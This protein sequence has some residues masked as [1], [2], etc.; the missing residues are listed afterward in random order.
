[1][2]YA[3]E[4]SCPTPGVDRLALS[5]AFVGAWA[6]AAPRSFYDSFPDLGRHW[7]VITGPY[8]E[9]FVRDVGGLY[10]SLLTISLWPRP[11]RRRTWHGWSAWRRPS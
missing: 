10:L 2:F 7:V 5:A 8:S 1:V 3:H 4:S 6:L 11:E 9:H